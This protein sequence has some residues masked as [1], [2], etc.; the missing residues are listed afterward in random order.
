MSKSY[1][2]L[3]L[4]RKNAQC[5]TRPSYFHID[6]IGLQYVQVSCGLNHY[7]LSYHGH[8]HTQQTDRHTDGHES[9][10]VAVDKPQL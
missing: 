8:R 10:I 9:S 1:C 6:L 4:D 5:R 7:F 2:D 3:D